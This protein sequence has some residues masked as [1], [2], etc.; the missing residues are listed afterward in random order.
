MP[1]LSSDL[2]TS[3]LADADAGPTRKNLPAVLA[4]YDEQATFKDP[5]NEVSG[6]AAIDR[7]FRHMFDAL[8]Q[9]R[10]VVRSAALS[11]E[12]PHAIAAGIP[13]RESGFAITEIGICLSIVNRRSPPLRRADFPR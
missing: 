10:F 11:G 2:R 5:F 8:R 6:R 13:Q 7:I 1:A 4:L 9:P 3:R 12:L